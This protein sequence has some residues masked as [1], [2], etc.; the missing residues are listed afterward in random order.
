MTLGCLSRECQTSHHNTFMTL[1]DVVP[2]KKGFLTFPEGVML[3]HFFI[4]LFKTD[5]S[6]V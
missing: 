4:T 3:S 5:K 6:S 1:Y 2:V